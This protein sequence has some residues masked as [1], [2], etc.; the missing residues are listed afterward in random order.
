MPSELNSGVELMLVGM[1]TVFVFL[2]LL[3]FVTRA[4]SA[5]VQRY[6]PSPDEVPTG[7]ATPA[8][9]IAEEEI[10]AISIAMAEHLRNRPR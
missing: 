3:V 7:A 4:M 10:A 2:T 9:G 8:G 6:F 1:G 5:I